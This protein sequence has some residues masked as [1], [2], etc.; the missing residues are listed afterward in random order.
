MLLVC[1][2][3]S[4]DKLGAMST[5]K[6]FLNSM[7]QLHRPFLLVGFV[8]ITLFVMVPQMGFVA[9]D[10]GGPDVPIIA[11]VRNHTSAFSSSTRK[12]QRLQHIHN[13]VALALV[14]TQ[15]RHLETDT[16][17]LVL[18]DGRPTQSFCALRC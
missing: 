17:D 13:T 4:E 1:H 7:K 16:I 5:P 11:T 9:D 10:D 12:N 2:Y 8:A 3:L 6:G 18:R 14:A 15:P